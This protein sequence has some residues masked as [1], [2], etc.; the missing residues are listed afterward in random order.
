ILWL[1]TL[2]GGRVRSTLTTLN[3]NRP[4]IG[5]IALGSLMGP[6]V[7]VWLS[8]VAVQ[9]SHVGVASTLMAMTPVLIL[10]VVRWGLKEQ[11]SRRAVLG[12][13]VS[14]VGVAVI[15]VGG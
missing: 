7:G 5:R 1:A 2:V 10:P 14:I 15:F 13:L 3:Q 8:L 11:V 4:V 9:A 6:F 12:T